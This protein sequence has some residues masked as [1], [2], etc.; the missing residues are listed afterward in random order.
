M[1]TPF[2]TAL[3]GPKRRAPCEDRGCGG[4]LLRKQMVVKV[5]SVAK[6]AKHKKGV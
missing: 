2:E 1:P 6:R 4:A 5:L 3:R